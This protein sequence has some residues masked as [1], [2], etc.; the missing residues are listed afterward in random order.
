MYDVVPGGPASVAGILPGDLILG[1]DKTPVGAPGDVVDKLRAYPS[2][3]V[4]TIVVQRAG[5]WIAL[6]VTLGLS[7]YAD[8]SATVEP[9]LT[10]TPTRKAA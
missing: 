8:L 6:S 7:P 9:S 3:T 4:V 1:I 5:R 10:P 2:G